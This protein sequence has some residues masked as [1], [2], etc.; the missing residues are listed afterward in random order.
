MAKKRPA[1]PKPEKPARSTAELLPKGYEELLGQIN[2]NRSSV[3]IEAGVGIPGVIRRITASFSR[4]V[5]GRSPLEA[6][7]TTSFAGFLLAR[8]LPP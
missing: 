7:C 4:G 8:R 6:S 5:R 3:P 1:K 2:G